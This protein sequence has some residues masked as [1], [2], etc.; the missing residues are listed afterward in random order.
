MRYPKVVRGRCPPSP[1]R[2][3]IKSPR[4]C[5]TLR[6]AALV[7]PASCRWRAGRDSRNRTVGSFRA[8]TCQPD[9]I[10]PPGRTSPCTHQGARSLV[11]C[12]HDES[13]QLPEPPGEFPSTK[14][15]RH[16]QDQERAWIVGCA[17]KGTQTIEPGYGAAPAAHEQ[18][19]TVAA[20][21][22]R[23]P[24]GRVDIQDSCWTYI[25]VRCAFSFCFQSLSRL[26]WIGY[27]RKAGHSRDCGI[28]SVR[29][30]PRYRSAVV[31]GFHPPSPGRTSPCT[32][33]GAR[34]LDPDFCALRV[35]LLFPIFVPPC[36]DTLLSW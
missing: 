7:A 9:L 35:F 30:T 22:C 15:D 27:P 2:G 31:R 17:L 11:S 8:W 21:N 34:S 20:P 12:R 4:F 36:V 26:A 18:A 3:P 33:Q 23:Q 28:A 25:F 32:H 1:G 13:E 16:R 19:L 29:A 24:D 5:F 14:L 10:G 6:S